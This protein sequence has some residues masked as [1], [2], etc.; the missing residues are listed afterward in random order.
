MAS[1]SAVIPAFETAACIQYQNTQGFAD[2]FAAFDRNP[3][4]RAIFV[5][6]ITCGYRLDDI[7][8][9]LL[10]AHK[11]RPTDTVKPM[12][13][14][15][16]GNAMARVPAMLA[17]AGCTNSASIEQAVAAAVAAARA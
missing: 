2:A 5:N 3:A 8:E 16:R 17:A 9:D 1:R 11:A 15:L 10:L 4:I 14:H 13:L 12:I 6:I 7:V